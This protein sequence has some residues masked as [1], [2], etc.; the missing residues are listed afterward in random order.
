MSDAERE[1]YRRELQDRFTPGAR[2]FPM[3]L[4]GLNSLANERIEDAIARG[5]FR[6]IPR[7]KGKHVERDHT[8]ANPYLDTTEYL[9][10]RIMQKQEVTPEWIQKQQELK[11]ETH[12][13]RTQLRNDW[14]RH[15]ARLIS[16]QGGTLQTQIRRAQ[17]YALAEAKQ[18][19]SAKASFQTEEKTVPEI[20]PMTQIDHEG[21][22]S[23]VPPP[24]SCSSDDSLQSQQPNSSLA[25]T[26]ISAEPL[27]NLP[28]LRD[29]QYFNIEKEYHDLKIKKLNE[30]IRSYNLLAPRVAQRP[31]LKL[32][33]ELDSCYAEVAPSLADEVYRRAT[34]RSHESSHLL[35]EGDA[36]VL[37]QTLGLGKSVRVHDEDK[38]KGYGLKQFWRDL[39]GSGA[40]T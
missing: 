35:P 25:N 38:S 27:P 10:N 6:N 29:P 19:E 18:N 11:L 28:C 3:S 17:A 36:S 15:A 13:F 30:M 12:R 20:E 26:G 23:R 34:E 33:R 16:S 21:K 2:A 40:T 39:W 5:Q 1:A 24:A 4:H 9:M 22:I 8:A 14:K 37:Q 32:Q 31:Y 7:G